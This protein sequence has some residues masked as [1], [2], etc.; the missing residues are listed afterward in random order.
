[1][2]PI[3]RLRPNGLKEPKIKTQTPKDLND[4]TKHK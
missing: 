2:A 3:F 1:M 4:F